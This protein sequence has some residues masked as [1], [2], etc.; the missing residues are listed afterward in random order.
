MK[1]E[2]Q[3]LLSITISKILMGP[4]LDSSQEL[5]GQTLCML[6]HCPL[7]R[8]DRHNG[9]LKL[10]RE[11]SDVPLLKVEGSF[12]FIIDSIWVKSI[13]VIRCFGDI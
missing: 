12:P 7:W 5:Q 1:N 2:S 3:M 10:L 8:R 11:L 9:F 6:N 13:A 4:K